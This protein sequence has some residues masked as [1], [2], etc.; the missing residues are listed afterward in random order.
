MNN[1]PFPF[2][3]FSI[4]T[5]FLCIYFRVKDNKVNYCWYVTNIW[6]FLNPSYAVGLSNY[7]SLLS[8]TCVA[9]IGTTSQLIKFIAIGTRTYS[10]YRQL[11]RY[12]TCTTHTTLDA[13][14][15]NPIFSI[16]YVEVT[17]AQLSH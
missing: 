12:K 10:S 6:V 13:V 8:G 1:F 16:K 17:F 3:N 15:Y 14:V 7:H 5:Q 4:T 2:S 11:L 9:F